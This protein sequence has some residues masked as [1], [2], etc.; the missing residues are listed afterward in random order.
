[1]VAANMTDMPGFAFSVIILYYYFKNKDSFEKKNI[2]NYIFLG[3][4]GGFAMLARE[5]SIFFIGLVVLIHLIE[6]LMDK[7]Y[8]ISSFVKDA[9]WWLIPLAIPFLFVIPYYYYYLGLLPWQMRIAEI[10]FWVLMDQPVFEHVVVVLLSAFHIGNLYY[11]VG[12]VHGKSRMVVYNILIWIVFL[13]QKTLQ[14]FAVPFSHNPQYRVI[15]T[16][17]PFFIPLIIVGIRV[18]SEE[19][20]KKE[21]FNVLSYEIWYVIF[22]IAYILVSFILALPYLN[23]YLLD[24]L[25][26]P[27]Y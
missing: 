6:G 18:I 11:I 12:F 25:N 8:N 22:V 3:L 13:I 17:F 23:Q 19:F 26:I 16:M 10:N 20:S 5:T 24:T 7:K 9:L 27:D 2:K 1:M 15:F 21:L 14:F 4:I